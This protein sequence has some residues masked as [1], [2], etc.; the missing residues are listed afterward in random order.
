LWHPLRPAEDLDELRLGGD[1]HDLAQ[2]APDER[3]ELVVVEPADASSPALP[4]KL[5][6]STWPSG[7]R[8][9]NL[10]ELQVVAM[11]P[12]LPGAR[13]DVASRAACVTRS[14]RKASETVAVVT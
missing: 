14:R 10:L 9:R 3:G 6:T 11:T 2:L 4:M 7:A 5:R 1:V 12:R 13:H 8:W